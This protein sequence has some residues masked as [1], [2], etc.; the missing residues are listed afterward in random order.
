MQLTLTGTPAPGDSF[1]IEPAPTRDV[2]ATL[3][4]LADAL[5]APVS[6]AAERAR[7]DNL[8]GGALGDIATAQDHMLALRSARARAG[9]AGRRRDTRS[10]SDLSLQRRCRSCARGFAKPQAGV[11]AAHRAGSGAED[12]LRVRDCAFGM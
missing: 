9:R 12:E 4:G 2:F 7:R 5:E 3:Q 6:N 10:A 1:A 8:I 11:A